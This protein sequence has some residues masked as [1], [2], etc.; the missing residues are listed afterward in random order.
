[1]SYRLLMTAHERS[2]RAYKS[3]VT[4]SF[5]YCCTLGDTITADV[6]EFK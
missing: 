2:V 6:L 5:C 4:I 1:M 3:L